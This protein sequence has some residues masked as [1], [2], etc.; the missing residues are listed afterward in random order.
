LRRQEFRRSTHP[1]LGNLKTKGDRS[2]VS[3]DPAQKT[4]RF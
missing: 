3:I 2:W 4:R 1:F